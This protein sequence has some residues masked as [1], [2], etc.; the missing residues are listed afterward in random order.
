[1]EYITDADYTHAK[2][3]C[4]NFEMKN[5]EENHDL[6]VQRDTSFLDD[7]FE[8]F[9]N[10]SLVKYEIDP[11]RLLTAPGLARKA[12]LKRTKVNLNLL[13][14]IDMLFMVEYGIRDRIC[15]AIH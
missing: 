2:G 9:R 6:Y 8:N 5:L 15:H 11:A 13:T 12:A 3:V 14:D 1:M 7:V 10:M 4:K